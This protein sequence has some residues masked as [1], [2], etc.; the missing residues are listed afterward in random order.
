MDAETIK[1]GFTSDEGNLYYT[2]PTPGILLLP[3]FQ[4]LIVCVEDNIINGKID[5]EGATKDY[6]LKGGKE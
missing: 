3:D 2:L 1:Q 6:N 4:R 5:Y